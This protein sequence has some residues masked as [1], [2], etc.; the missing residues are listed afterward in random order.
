[1][2][3]PIILI[4]PFKDS[5]NE[6]T[7]IYNNYI[8]PVIQ[9]GGL[10]IIPAMSASQSDI[11][12]IANIAHGAIFTGGPDVCPENYGEERSDKVSPRTSHERDYF[13]SQ[14]FCSLYEQDKAVLAICRG[15]Q[16]MNVALGGTLYQDIPTSFPSSGLEHNQKEPFDE[17]SHII[18]IVELSPL[19]R[20]LGSSQ[21]GVNSS[22]HQSVKKLARGL[23]TMAAS[24]DGVVEAVYAVSK[25]FIWGIQWHPEFMF[26]NEPEDKPVNTMILEAFI[27]AAKEIVEDTSYETI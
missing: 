16:L 12:Q 14:L 15:M 11:K 18:D 3:K 17:I 9:A 27:Q 1:L 26:Y 7:F 21:I 8:E 2:D 4:L 19:E 13:E 22:H 6:R 5:E 24:G 10:P 20:L 25:P 23:E